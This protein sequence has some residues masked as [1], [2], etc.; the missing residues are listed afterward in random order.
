MQIDAGGD[1]AERTR[2][3]LG[4]VLDVLLRLLHPTIPFVTELLWTTLTGRDSVVVADWPA[5]TGEHADEGA[6]QRVLAVQKLITEVRRFRSDQGLK[7]GQRVAARLGGLD[8]LGL[9]EHSAAVRSLAKLNEPGEEFTS[10]ASLEVGLTGGTVPVELDLSG[11]VDVAAERKR[12]EKDLAAAR[13]ELDGTDKK[14]ANPS[15]TDKAPAAV[16]DKIKVRRDTAQ[17]DIERIESR[18]A[19]LPPA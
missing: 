8:A 4:H 12:L 3:V 19:A 15:F 10:S 1:R 14:L 11:A 16:V 2:D 6:A 17:S 13:K 9:A 5:T 7:P 18:L